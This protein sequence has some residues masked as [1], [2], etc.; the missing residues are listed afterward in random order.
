[1]VLRRILF[2]T[3]FPAV[4]LVALLLTDVYVRLAPESSPIARGAA[5]PQVYS[6]L[7]CH[8]N[9]DSAARA[10]WSLS[11]ES[12]ST[13]PGHPDYQGQ[14]EDLL[15]F[16]AV[17]RVRNTL[18]ERMNDN[19]ENRLLA[20][21]A[22]ARKFYCFQCHGELGQGG[23]PNLGSLKGYVPGYF[24]NDFR[25]LTSNAS[26]TAVTAWIVEGTNTDILNRF[27]EG[28][29][30]EF[31]FERQAIQMPSH[32]SLSDY[33]LNLLVDYVLALQAMGPMDAAAVRHYDQLT[34]QPPNSTGPSHNMSDRA[35]RRT[36][37]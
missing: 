2:C 30:A 11:C 37:N 1:M 17:A 15:A 14:C 12:Q 27:I 10:A 9:D 16:F 26:P 7:T 13:A 23:Y 33:E 25:Q 35:L 5:I 8:G 4:G 18:I 19:P 36:P 29:I 22:L 28:P 6:C 24:G 32:N 20:G 34:R 21:E 3:L 31:F